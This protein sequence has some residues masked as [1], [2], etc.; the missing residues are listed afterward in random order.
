[1]TKEP[2]TCHRRRV[3]P[4]STILDRFRRAAGVPATV[5]DELAGELAPLFLALD[6][7]EEESERIRS[8]ADESVERRLAAAREGAAG[9]SAEAHRRAEAGRARAL[10]ERR[11][12]QEAEAQTLRA[13]AEIEAREI[14]ERGAARVPQ[15]VAEVVACVKAG[16]E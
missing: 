15:L 5:G 13:A 2:F 12:A 1:M 14:R 10:A 16:P 9:E 7:I 6:S 8:A 11:E 3:Q 4:V